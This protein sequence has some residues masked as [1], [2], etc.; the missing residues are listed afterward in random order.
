MKVLRPDCLACHGHVGRF[1]VDD[2]ASV[3]K[4]FRVVAFRLS[5][6]NGHNSIEAVNN[7]VRG[8]TIC[9]SAHPHKEEMRNFHPIE[10]VQRPHLPRHYPLG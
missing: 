8:S 6:E 7:R 5:S 3:H 4:V 1:I 10:F 2:D 9:Q